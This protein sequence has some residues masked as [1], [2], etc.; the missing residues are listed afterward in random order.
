MKKMVRLCLPPQTDEGQN[1]VEQQ[2]HRARFGGQ[3]EE[4]APF[5]MRL[6][7]EEECHSSAKETLR[8]GLWRALGQ[9]LES[10]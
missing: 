8:D 4:S 3:R 1:H 9:R 2:A 6:R 7:R 10:G 5:S